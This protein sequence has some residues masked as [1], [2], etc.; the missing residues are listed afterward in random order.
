M[1][2]GLLVVGCGK[3]NPVQ[4]LANKPITSKPEEV[5]RHTEADK[6]GFAETKSKAEA[7]DA[8]AQYNIGVMYYEG[9]GVA[10]DFKE[11]IGWTLKAANQ[12]HKGAQNN[13][14]VIYYEGQVV[15]QDFKEAVKW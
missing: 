1:I 13:L 10:R 8:L 5:Q 15:E 7:G 3:K 2:L 6:K 9:K 11:A 12:G 14:G 4:P